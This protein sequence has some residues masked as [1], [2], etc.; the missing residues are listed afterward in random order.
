MDDRV[1][2]PEVPTVA[3][4]AWRRLAE[5]V[6][7]IAATRDLAGLMAI[8][9]RAARE[10]T[11]ADGATLVLREGTMCH[12]AD[13][14]AIGPLWKGQRFPLGSCIS[15]WAM[16]HAEA[17]A[18]EDIYA[19]ERIPHAAYRPTFVQSLTMVPI[20]RRA[21]VGAIGCY[22]SRRHRATP[23]QLALQQALADAAAVG[24]AN[25]ELLR[26]LESALAEAEAAA[27]EAKGSEARLAEDV[28][29]RKEA[30]AR[31][32]EASRALAQE[33]RILQ[34]VMDGAGNVSRIYLDRDFNFVRVNESYARTCGYTPEEMIGRNHFD[35]YPHKE[36]EAIF[37]QVRDTGEPY[38]ARDKPFVFPD[39][40]ERGV[41]YWDWSL[42]P[43]RSRTGEV[44]G[45]VFA[46][47][48]TTERKRAEKAQRATDLAR[49]IISVQEEERHRLSQVV[50]D[51]TSPNLA[52]IELNL[53]M[54]AGS[55]QGP[56][57]EASAARI[58]DSQALLRDTAANLREICFELRPAALDYFGLV[59]AIDSYAQQFRSRT[60]MAVE[61]RADEPAGSLAPELENAAFRIVQ[62]ALTNCAKHSRAQRVEVIV[63]NRQPTGLRLTV[64]D[65]GVG[66]AAAAPDQPGLGLL[67]MRERAELAGGRFKLESQ[68]GGGTRI[69]AEL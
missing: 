46:L 40:P 39:Q 6:E 69:V 21:P 65:D 58:E 35:L 1:S 16:L 9:R 48:E 2:T 5:V 13:E 50:H 41:T 51:R 62:E 19:D 56:A 32:I 33:K 34:H 64:S 45:L 23:E 20:G 31:L 12:Y 3:A 29:R 10:L 61:V 7:R 66:F 11:G 36:N 4:G 52:A 43:I 22:W 24:L 68:P 26:R 37:M 15:G 53:R 55:L 17:V 60:G 63:E 28:Q 8:V 49:S 18:I 27:R 42:R 30:E 38:E 67:T 25:L 57:C 14:D 59:P 44:E 47:V 54:I